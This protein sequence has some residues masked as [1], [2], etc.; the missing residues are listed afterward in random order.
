MEEL[1]NRLFS[2]FTKLEKI[3]IAISSIFLTTVL[4]IM[5]SGILNGVISFLILYVY[6]IF[7]IG[8]FISKTKEDS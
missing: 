5:T 3:F 6:I 1:Y 4:L 8:I 2:R 7:Y